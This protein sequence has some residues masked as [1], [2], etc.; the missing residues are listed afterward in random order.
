MNQIDFNKIRKWILIGAV[1]MLCVLVGI[2]KN[3]IRIF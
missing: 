1:L 3:A 2:I